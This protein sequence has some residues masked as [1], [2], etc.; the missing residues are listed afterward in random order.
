MGLIYYK[1]EPYGKIE[2]DELQFYAVEGDIEELPE[3]GK[4]LEKI[5]VLNDDGTQKTT[6]EGKKL[7]KV[8]IPMSYVIQ[9]ANILTETDA[10]YIINK[11]AVDKIE[12]SSGTRS[13][14]NNVNGD[15]VAQGIRIIRA[16]TVEN[17]LNKVTPED[18]Y[19][20]IT[21]NEYKFFSCSYNINSTTITQNYTEYKFFIVN[22]G[23][24]A[25][26]AP[27]ASS[28]PINSRY[29]GVAFISDSISGNS[30]KTYP[31]AFGFDENKQLTG[32]SPLSTDN[33][34]GLYCTFTLSDTEKEYAL[35]L[36]DT[37]EYIS[38]ETYKNEVSSK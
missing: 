35:G 2:D 16:D 8:N 11:Q 1:G 19:T 36:T 24:N 3:D 4:E 29:I 34:L 25:S 21:L 7:W 18:L 15:F 30:A 10:E 37:Y 27:I 13:V 17:A 20:A 23:T 38:E 12:L 14:F 33:N 22:N 31:Y 28:F 26:K 6:E 5:P 9:N 32:N